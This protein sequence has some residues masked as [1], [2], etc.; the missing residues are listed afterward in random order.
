MVLINNDYNNLSSACQI[1][2]IIQDHRYGCM[3]KSGQTEPLVATKL[4][5]F[6]NGA[7][8][9]LSKWNDWN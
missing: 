8:V 6:T 9:L 7:C 3:A 4:C 1:S 5:H 2:T